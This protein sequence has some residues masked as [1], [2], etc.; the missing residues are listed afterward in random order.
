MGGAFGSSRAP[1][2]DY[3]RRSTAAA[4]TEQRIERTAKNR[5][6]QAQ[7][8]STRERISL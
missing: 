3:D 2:P 7:D 6:R 1:V 8:Q 5:M 4:V